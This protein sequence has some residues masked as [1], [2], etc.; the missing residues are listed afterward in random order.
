[1]EFNSY[2]VYTNFLFRRPSLS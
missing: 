1:M 2:N